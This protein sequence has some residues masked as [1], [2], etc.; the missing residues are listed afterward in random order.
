M[1]LTRSAI[2]GKT[3]KAIALLLFLSSVL[4]FQGCSHERLTA[5][6]AS[7]K[8]TVQRNGITNRFGVE[9]RETAAIFHYDGYSF[10]GERLKVKI[11]NDQVVVN[12]KM[13]GKLKTGDSVQIGDD[14]ITVNSLDHGQTEKYLQANAGQESVQTFN[15]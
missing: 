6:F 3:T 14:G 13:L 11:E 5:N 12:D 15:K 9:E 10:S 4:V 2:H 7:H 1:K 8:V